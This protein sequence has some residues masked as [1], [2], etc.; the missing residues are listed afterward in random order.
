RVVVT[1]ATIRDALH[2][3]DAEGLDCLPNEEIFTTLARMGYEKQST[4]LIF[5]KAFF[6]SQWKFLI[7]TILQLMSAKQTSWNEFRSAMTSAGDEEEQSNNDNATEEPVIAVVDV[8][9][10]TF[11][12]PTP[13]TPPPQQ[14]QNI[15]SISQVQPPPPQQQSP[16]PAQPQG[17]HFPISLLQ[18]ALDACTALARRVKHLEHD[19]VAQDLEIIMLKSRVKK[20]ERDN[21]VKSM[22]LRILRK[23]GT[24]Q[25]IESPDDTI[26][27]D[28]SNQGRMLD[29]T[30]KDEDAE[31]INEKEEKETEEVRV[32]SNDAQVKGRQADIYHIDMDHATKVLISAAAVV[33]DDVQAALVNA[34]AVV[35]TAAPVKVAVPY[36]RRRRGVVIRDPEEESSA[37]TP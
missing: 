9:D 22:K 33:Q 35:T 10:Q 19:K 24:S 3:D 28:V 13:L 8:E 34:A 12:S 2:L 23:V 20:I 31:L 21:K 6:S 5:Y 30:D 15:P 25:R 29:E 1:E 36:T 17:A 16:P 14:P 11:Q 27:E 7:H 18:E 26:I 32:N 4:K 37:K